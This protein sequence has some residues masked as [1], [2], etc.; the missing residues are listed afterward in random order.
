VKVDTFKDKKEKYGRYLAKV[1]YIT[2]DLTSSVCIND[3]LIKNG[4]AKE[5]YGRA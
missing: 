1:S 2:E 3:E 4:L 5:Y